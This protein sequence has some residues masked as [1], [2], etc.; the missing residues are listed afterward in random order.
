MTAQA[1]A[2]SSGY[3]LQRIRIYESHVRTGY[4]RVFGIAFGMLGNYCEAEDAAQETFIRAWRHL[5]QYDGRHPFQSWLTA[6]AR[7]LVRDQLRK[8]KSQNACSLD[9][10]TTS[11]LEGLYATVASTDETSN[12][13]RQLLSGEVCTTYRTVIDSLPP[14]YQEIVALHDFDGLSYTEIARLLRCP[15]GTVRSR[16]HRGRALA[17]HHLQQ[18]HPAFV[19][20]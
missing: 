1:P 12:P 15:L 5:G 16:L 14:R 4:K 6:I 2:N 10:F 17:R 18:N 9:M 7:N 13:E 20:G 3:E 11:G 8:R 19:S